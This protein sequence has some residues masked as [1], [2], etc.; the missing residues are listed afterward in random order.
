MVF[1]CESDDPSKI[2]N[3]IPHNL[4]SKRYRSHVHE[5]FNSAV[6]VSDML[7]PRCWT[8]HGSRKRVKADFWNSYAHRHICLRCDSWFNLERYSYRVNHF[9]GQWWEWILFCLNWLKTGYVSLLNIPSWTDMLISTTLMLKHKWCAV[10]CF[11]LVFYF[12]HSLLPHSDRISP[13]LVLT[14]ES[15]Q[16]VHNQCFHFSTSW[17]VKNSFLVFLWMLAIHIHLIIN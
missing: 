12:Q 13:L 11:I 1:L 14:K 17:C 6:M 10:F 9:C 2:Q 7:S 3:T 15:D 8:R 5:I 4:V 16:K